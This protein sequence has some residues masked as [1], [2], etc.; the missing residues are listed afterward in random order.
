M[1]LIPSSQQFLDSYT[2]A[3]PGAGFAVNYANIVAL[4][5]DAMAGDVLLDGVPVPAEEFSVL[6][7]T[8]FSATQAVIGVGTHTVSAPNP[9]GLYVYGFAESDSYGYPGGFSA[10]TP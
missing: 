4:T 3:T 9:A 8:D 6:T 2:F 1:M 10:G 7:G 5:T